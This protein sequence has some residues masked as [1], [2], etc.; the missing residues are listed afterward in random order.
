[1]HGQQKFRRRYASS[2]VYR[3]HQRVG[4]RKWEWDIEYMNNGR[5]HLMFD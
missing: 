1:M 4:E 2:D 5:T 3:E